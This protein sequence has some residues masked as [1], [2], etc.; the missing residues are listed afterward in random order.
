[1]PS[2]LPRIVGYYIAVF[3]IFLTKSAEAQC[4]G[5]NPFMTITNTTTMVGNG[6][7]VYS[8][9]MF[10]PSS[11]TLF[12]VDFS[13]RFYSYYSYSLINMNAAP[14]DYN[15]IVDRIDNLVAFSDMDPTPIVLLEE[16]NT[17][18]IRYNNTPLPRVP[19]GTTNYNSTIYSNR[20]IPVITFDQNVVPFLGMDN[21]YL[22]YNTNTQAGGIGSPDVNYSNGF[23]RD[24]VIVTLTYNYCPA[25][26]LASSLIR[27]G[28][29]ARSSDLL[30]SWST[31]DNVNQGWFELLKSTDGRTYTSIN[32]QPIDRM[33][34]RGYSYL[35]K[36]LAT[37]GNKGFFRIR[38][39]DKTG[40]VIYSKVLTTLIP[41][42]AAGTAT[43]P[44][45]MLTVFP[46]ITADDFVNVSL[47]KTNAGDEWEISILSLSGQVL[48]NSVL[49]GSGQMKLLFSHH[50]SNGMHIIHAVN[51]RTRTSYKGKVIVKH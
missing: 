31:E 1:M 15:F 45:G 5:G 49:K 8:L 32:K 41:R 4:P 48:Q 2:T 20:S 50:L 46:G 24:S 29:V 36:P 35:Y 27:I 47:P 18:T 44:S 21:L 19:P 6:N 39:T 28:S 11:G 43:Q 25:A 33:N 16:S 42:P 38:Q 9:P 14:Q 40:N 17:R 7:N 23:S 34:L 3:C 37:D 30:V 51:K 22:S 12:S 13:A 26:T 10:D